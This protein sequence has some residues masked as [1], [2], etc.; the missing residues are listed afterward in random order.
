MTESGPPESGTP[1]PPVNADD[2]KRV[3][4]LIRNMVVDHGVSGIDERMISRQ[5]EA[6][7]DGNA[8]FFRAA[9]LLYL[10]QSGVLHDWCEGNEPADPVFRVGAVF[11]MELGVQGFDPAGFMERLRS[12]ES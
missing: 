4:G 5:C 11:P 3:W 7:A 2:L 12:A 1:L 8:V 10:F 9:L 6:G